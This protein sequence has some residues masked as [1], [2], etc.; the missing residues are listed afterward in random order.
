MFKSLHKFII[1]IILVLG[2]SISLQSLL[3]WEVPNSGPATPN[4][5]KPINEGILPQ[6]KSGDFTTSSD[7]GVGGS[8]TVTGAVNAASFMYT[9]DR[10]LKKDI[11]PINNSLQRILSL[12]GVEFKWKDSDD[13]NIGLI[14]QDV[15]KVF[16]E[17]V[18]TSNS[19][20]KSVEYGNIVAPLIE[21]IKEQQKQ[22]DYLKE[23]IYEIENK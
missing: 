5:A 13:L 2:L 21:A 18:H 4:I 20:I 23:K 16:P 9:S 14:A 19:G 8:I 3:A 11:N 6:T 7:L 22:I 1:T 10:G 15:E 12:E 17:I